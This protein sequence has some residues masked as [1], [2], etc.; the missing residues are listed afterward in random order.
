MTD[1][2]AK[3]AERIREWRASGQSAP[4]YA[5]GR[6]FEASTLRWWASRLDRAAAAA[7]EGES[8]T[9]SG[10]RM[11]RVVAATKPRSDVLTVRIGAAQVEVRRGFDRRLL[12]ELVEAL[13]ADR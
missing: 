5:Q 7:A 3:W 12:R 9:A 4:E 8:S 2:E 1:T 6:G 13:G 10:V 11:V